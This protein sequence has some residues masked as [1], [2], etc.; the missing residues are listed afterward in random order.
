MARYIASTRDPNRPAGEPE[1]RALFGVK[2]HKWPVSGI[3]VRSI[4][5]IM[6]GVLPFQERADGRKS[7]THR[8]LAACPDCAR[9]MSVSRLRQHKCK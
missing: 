6:V 9:L 5:G 7:S 2:G 8:V 4:Q 1:M 3:P